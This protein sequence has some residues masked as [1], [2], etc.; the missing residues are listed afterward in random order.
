MQQDLPA[1]PSSAAPDC[2]QQHPACNREIQQQPEQVDEDEIQQPPSMA[3]ASKMG[4]VAKLRDCDRRRH[5]G[6]SP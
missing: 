1:Y 3:S 6:Q 2:V 5:L 4:H